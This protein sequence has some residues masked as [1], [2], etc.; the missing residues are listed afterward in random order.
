[1]KCLTINQPYAALIITPASEMPSVPG[2]KR[3]ENR[4]WG[5]TYRGPLLIHAGKSRAWERG[6][7]PA[8]LPPLVYG[9]IVG[10]A[11]LQD[12]VPLNVLKKSP[13]LDD[14]RY[15]WVLTHPHT[16]GPVCWIL[17]SVERF[18]TPIPWRGQQGL[19]D[20]PDHVVI[21]QL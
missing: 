12:C 21:S 8:L 16:E 5:T 17:A 10:V 4:R 14:S 13:Q 2:P 3:V 7:N 18:V 6:W 20:V 19:F 15:E 1:M 11:E 9:A